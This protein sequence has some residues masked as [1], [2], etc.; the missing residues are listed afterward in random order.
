MLV[1]FY[2]FIGGDLNVKNQHYITDQP[3]L[4]LLITLTCFK[5]LNKEKQKKS[6]QTHPTPRKKKVLARY[7]LNRTKGKNE[8]F[9]S[10]M[11]EHLS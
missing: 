1:L 6:R 4:D 7:V 2:Y 9:K 8:F 5:G 11:T 3:S 10:K